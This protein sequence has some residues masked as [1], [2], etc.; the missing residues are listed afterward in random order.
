M[1][2]VKKL[3]ELSREKREHDKCL[4]EC[5]SQK[6]QNVPDAN[7]MVESDNT[8]KVFPKP[9]PGIKG[10]PRLF[11]IGLCQDEAE[12]SIGRSKGIEE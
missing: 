8:S 4:E 7:S 2:E 3:I 5:K 11:V 9:T 10:R 1:D 12:I 6:D